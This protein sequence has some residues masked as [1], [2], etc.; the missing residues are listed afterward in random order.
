VSGGVGPE[1][2]IQTTSGRRFPDLVMERDSARIA[3]QVGRVNKNGQPIARE[4][5]IIDELKESGQFTDVVFVP[6]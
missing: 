1:R 3:V 4:Q 5:R 2:A 6:Y